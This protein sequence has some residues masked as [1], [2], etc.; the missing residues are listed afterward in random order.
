M[1][2]L[3]LFFLLDN[4]L[5]TGVYYLFF[6]LQSTAF[7]QSIWTA[8]WLKAAAPGVMVTGASTVPQSPHPLLS[9]RGSVPKY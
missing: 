2:C 9:Q 6:S 1:I 3:Y 7:E 4:E 5:S 8:R